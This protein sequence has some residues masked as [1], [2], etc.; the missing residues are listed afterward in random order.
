MM[1]GTG[2]SALSTQHS[3]LITG[4]AGFIGANFVQY[5]MAAHPHDRVVV[6]DA[7]TYAGNPE[8]LKPVRDRKGFAFVHGDIRDRALV[9]RL[10]RE[11][12]VDCIVHFAAESHVDRSIAGPDA[13]VQTNVLGTFALLEAARAYRD[14]GAPRSFRF[15][16]VS[17]D[18]VYGSLGPIDPPFREDTPYAPNSPYAASKAGSDHLVRAYHH[19]YDLPVTT[20]NCSNN[21]GPYQFPE[22]L[23]PFMI[24]NALEGRPLP[25]YGD[26][27]NIRDWL[28]VEDHCRGIELVLEKGRIGET[29][30]IGGNNERNNLDVVRTLCRL[31]D[32]LLPG[33]S[34]VPHE[35]LI[36]FV[37]DRKGHDRRYAIDA[38]RAS[39]EL[40]YLP[41]VSFDE[42]LKRTV[43]WYL[44]NASWWRAVMDGSYREWIR[45]YYGDRSAGTGCV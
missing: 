35:R 3:L 27:L 34:R 5:W 16:H 33:S 36:T 29:Y 7:L 45:K 39:R 2:N 4:G 1:H 40:G 11:H 23:I 42:G 22:K 38:S 19:T 17:T 21:Y 12:S 6:L 32:R 9:D 24:V 37:N 15:H 41:A 18:E 25:I 10:L 14:G 28:Y 31:L 13:F 30:N 26:G 20:S 44:A 43:E 8:S